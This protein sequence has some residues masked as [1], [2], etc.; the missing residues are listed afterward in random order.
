MYSS[1]LSSKTA[2]Q[3]LGRGKRKVKTP[4]GGNGTVLQVSQ[5]D[6]PISRLIGDAT[7]PVIQPDQLLAY[8]ANPA[9]VGKPG[10]S[11]WILCAGTSAKTAAPSC[12]GRRGGPVKALTCG[13]TC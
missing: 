13:G 11:E 8:P 12:R 1:A 4:T 3:P 5:A 9:T 7:E 10:D 2:T 6:R